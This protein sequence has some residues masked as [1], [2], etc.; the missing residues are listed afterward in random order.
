MRDEFAG[1]L[2][3]HGRL[4]NLHSHTQGPSKS[5]RQSAA[6]GR[7]IRAA[8]ATSR[9]VSGSERRTSVTASV[10]HPVHGLADVVTDLSSSSGRTSLISG[11]PSTWSKYLDHVLPNLAAKLLGCNG[12]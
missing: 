12:P 1:G 9:R 8:Q 11:R 3:R 5:D 4:R 6:C 10:S 7:G 2:F